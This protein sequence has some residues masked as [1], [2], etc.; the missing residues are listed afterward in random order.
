MPNE[1]TIF[2]FE[3]DFAGSLQCIPM[4]VRFKLDMSGVKVSLRQW[5][6]FSHED[7]TQLLEQNCDIAT[8]ITLYRESLIKLIRAIPDEPVF[9]PAEM[10]AAWA[11]PSSVPVQIFDHACKVGIAPPSS[12]QWAALSPLQRF[13]LI[14][15][16]RDHHD[17]VNF[18][19]ALREF[20][21]LTI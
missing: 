9:L 11:D 7:R 5:N 15:L 21:V 16:S 20:G 8:D 14:K 12:E 1:T 3:T 10:D 13:T 18:I 17:N 4:A 19:P 2:D 6:R